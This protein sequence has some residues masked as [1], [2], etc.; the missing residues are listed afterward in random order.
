MSQVRA[1]GVFTV[2]CVA[3]GGRVR[4]ETETHN[5]V[6]NGGLQML[7]QQFFAGSGYT[8]AWYLGLYGESTGPLATDT[9]SNHPSW[10]EFV[11]Y[12]QTT[13]PQAVFGAATAASP[14]VISNSGAMAVFNITPVGPSLLGGIF[15]TT[16]PAKGGVLGELYSASPFPGTTYR[17]VYG[18]EALQ[19]I[20][21]H[22]ISAT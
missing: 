19:V 21:T 4:W 16:N 10:T 20:Y 18:G 1:G 7:S 12:S 15:L 2:R 5:L 11:G 3:P 9:M 6:T 13:R 22:L 14:S 17:T 8:A